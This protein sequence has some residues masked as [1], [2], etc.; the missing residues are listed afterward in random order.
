MLQIL[1]EFLKAH[2]DIFVGL[3][4]AEIIAWNPKWA[5]GSIGMLILNIIRGAAGN[6]PISVPAPAQAQAPK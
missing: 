6:P 4:I 5:S 1:L 3:L 2:A